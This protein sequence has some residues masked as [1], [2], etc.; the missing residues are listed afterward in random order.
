MFDYWLDSQIDERLH[1]KNEETYMLLYT[2]MPCKT[3]EE[4]SKR[5]TSTLVGNTLI[6]LHACMYNNN[7]NIAFCPKQVGVG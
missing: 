7:N 5:T 3:G 1:E 2:E 6:F 4:Y